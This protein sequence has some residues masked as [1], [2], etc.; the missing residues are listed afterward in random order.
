MESVNDTL[1][2]ECVHG[3]HFRTRTE[4]QQALVEYIGDYPTERRHSSLGKLWPA[5]FEERWYSPSSP[6]GVTLP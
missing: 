6:T 5:A 3:E 4:V 2:V 1:K